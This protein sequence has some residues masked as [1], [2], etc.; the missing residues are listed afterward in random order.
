ML[1]RKVIMAIADGLGDRPHPLLE[2][3]T[4]LEYAH[5]PNL[6]RLASEGITGM[7]DPISSGIPVGTDMGHL[8]L[9]GY[10]PHH[11]PGRGPIEAL[12]IGMEVNPGDIVLRCNFA[13][14]D[15][16]GIVVDRRAGR[17]RE[18]TEEIAQA[19][20]GMELKDGI[21]IF[22][23]PATEHRAVLILRGTGLSDKISDSDPKAPND[24]KPYH[25]VVPLDSSKEAERTAFILNMF[26]KSAHEILSSHPVNV[27][28]NAE[29]KLPAN[30]ILT[31]GAGQMVNLDPIVQELNIKG[32]CIAGESTVLGV[33]KL[34]GF[35]TVTDSKMTGNMDTNIE[36]KAR[37]AIKEIVENDMVY[38]H[39]KAPDVKGHDNEPFNKARA[40]ELFDQMVGL[41]DQQLPENVYLA[42]AADHSTPCEVGEHTGEPVPVLIYGPGIRRDRIMQYN[43]LDCAHGGLGHLTGNEFV[44]TLHGLIGIVKKQGN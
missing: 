22:F 27:E 7:M 1:K 29:G 36:L 20:N 33:A 28:R 30:F 10:Q 4:P 19:I 43:E 35:K 3:R 41:I 11:Y 21:E 8:I 23:K 25:Q 44:R 26:L 6:D 15:E 37:F 16:N 18:K 13:T 12:G 24:G 31:R 42:L 17:I 5:T 40:I 32:S 9:F 38:V 34:A 2:S 39:V 14:V